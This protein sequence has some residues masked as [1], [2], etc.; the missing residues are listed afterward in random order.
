MKHLIL[1]ATL[2][3]LATPTFA[4]SKPCDELK[5]EIAAKLD[6]KK[7]TGYKLDIVDTEKVGDAKVVGSC[8][9]G[10]KKIVY[11]RAAAK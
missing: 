8:D 5:T 10:K 6:E 11:G 4:A 3:A 9:G 2:L 1:S 7:V